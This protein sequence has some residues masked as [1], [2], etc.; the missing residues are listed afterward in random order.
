MKKARWIAWLIATL[1]LLLG[2][3]LT[4]APTSGKVV[5]SVKS[6]GTDV[7]GKVNC[8]SP[9]LYTTK[10]SNNEGCDGRLLARGGLVVCAVLLTVLS[11]LVGLVIFAI[12]RRHT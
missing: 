2:V 4:I 3:A 1:A 9:F 12:E 8:G 10:W 6:D 5:V 7:T 11:G